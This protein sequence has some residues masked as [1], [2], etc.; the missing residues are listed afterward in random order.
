MVHFVRALAQW[1][2]DLDY[3]VFDDSVFV[4]NYFLLDLIG[5]KCLF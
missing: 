5:R 1:G 2:G 3:S 4:V